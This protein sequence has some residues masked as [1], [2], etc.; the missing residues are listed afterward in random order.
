MADL[1]ALQDT[2]HDFGLNIAAGA[3][4]RLAE[5]C[6][7]LW[8]WN[9]RLN[10]TR[11]TTV[12]AFVTRD[13]ADTVPLAAEIA[14]GQTV[15]DVGSGGGVPGIPLAILRSDLTVAL[16]ESVQRKAA[17]LQSIVQSLELDVPVFPERAEDHLR[18][19]RYDVLTLRAVATL[20]RLLTWF[21]PAL[22]AGAAGELLLIKGPRWPDELQ[23]AQ[24]NRLTVGLTIDELARWS[25][26][27]RDGDSVLLRVA[28][29]DGNAAR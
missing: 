9:A 4:P 11:H 8:E 17:A 7:R 28:R 2:V 26:A 14:P 23:A 3:L 16:A 25:T 29:D 12:E 13:L 5:Y 18:Q 1:T 21:R 10:L 15:L 6:A 19:H 22:R 27:G 20:P 24:R